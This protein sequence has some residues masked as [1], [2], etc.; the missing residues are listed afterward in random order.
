[1]IPSNTHPRT[2]IIALKLKF[3]L[4]NILWPVMY[5]QKAD[6]ISIFAQ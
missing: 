3:E 5:G 6:P 1:M 2:H 4:N